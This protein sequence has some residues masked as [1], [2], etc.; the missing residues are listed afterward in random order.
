[1]DLF[2][3]AEPDSFKRKKLKTFQIKIPI[4]LKEFTGLIKK[5]KMQ[6]SVKIRVQ[7]EKNNFC[8]LQKNLYLLE[9]YELLHDEISLLDIWAHL[10][11]N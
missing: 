9:N 11:K 4:N 7:K 1:M 8:L 5:E 2:H 6:V 3:Y 10:N